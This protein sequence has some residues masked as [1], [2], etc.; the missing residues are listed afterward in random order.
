MTPAPAAAPKS[1]GRDRRGATARPTLRRILAQALPAAPEPEFGKGA[2]RAVI[3]G[4]ASDS[5]RVKA[6]DL[7]IA[8]RGAFHD[9]HDHLAQAEARGAA[10]ALV[11]TAPKDAPLPWA[12]VPD[13]RKAAGPVADAAYRSPSERLRLVGVTG[14][15]GKTTVAW[16]LDQAFRRREGAGL[17]AGTL[18]HR[19]SAG[20]R[21]SRLTEPRLTTW[22]APA[23]T[24]FLAR[25]EHAGCVFG[26]VECSSHGLALD[27]LSATRF[28]AAVFT[29]LTPD[30][31]DFHPDFEHY[32]RAKARLFTDL[33]RPQGTAVIS[34]DDARGRR[35]AGELRAARGDVRVLTYGANE[36]AEVRITETHSDLEGTRLLLSTPEGSL[37]ISSRLVGGFNTENLTAAWAAL[38]A[39]GV[40][41]K[42]AAD[43]LGRAQPPPGRMERAL[44]RGLDD[45][46]APVALVD[47]AHTPDA[48]ERALA[49]CR[50]IAGR[51]PLT[52]VFGCGGERDRVKRYLMGE[53]AARL[54]DR[55]VLTSD[56]PRTEDP[57]D[58]IEDIRRG[59]D[60][61]DA[62]RSPSLTIAPLRREAIGR[63]IRA[64]APGEVVL[65]A[66]R[67]H[68]THQQ[69]GGKRRAFSDRKAAEEA[70]RNRAAGP[71][72]QGA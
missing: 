1:A 54:A 2:E 47:Y 55:V 14:T 51:R 38:T 62:E 19:F 3:T 70:L 53:V 27:R 65:I 34:L 15:N 57:N 10:A 31:G 30:H 12:R 63:A 42:E 17:L 59:A 24:A 4:V 64:A 67:G 13:T 36:E 5:R 25:A 48:L 72:W 9:G 68:E 16:L 58:I 28:E 8:L 52:V 29:N 40:P 49:A 50:E 60:Q 46:E 39:L 23:L 18:G 22:E 61:P 71:G 37:G 11:E 69:I 20:G 41:G 66:G 6:G 21:Q 43:L 7:F 56:N 32:Y 35:L 44:P 33:L 45:P 26:A